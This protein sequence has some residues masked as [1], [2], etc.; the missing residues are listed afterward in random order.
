M[1]KTKMVHNSA[2]ST[3]LEIW[4]DQNSCQTEEELAQSLR[5]TQAAILSV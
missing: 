1:S 4:L 5:L 3:K 2:R